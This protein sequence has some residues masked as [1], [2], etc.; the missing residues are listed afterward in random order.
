MKYNKKNPRFR[1]ETGDFNVFAVSK[2][3]LTQ[4]ESLNDSTIS[5]DVA[6][7]QVVQQ[8][9]T[10]TYQ[11]CQCSFSAIIFSVELEVLSQVRNTV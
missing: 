9:T 7:L 4:A 5:V 2:K 6:I 10:L 8:S 11:C 3:L 1:L